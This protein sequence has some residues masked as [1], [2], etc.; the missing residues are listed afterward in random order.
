MI[1]KNIDRM[2]S[3]IQRDPALGAGEKLAV[4]LNRSCDSMLEDAFLLTP[5]GEVRDAFWAVSM[6]GCQ[7]DEASIT[8]TE[9]GAGV[10]AFRESQPS[11]RDGRPGG[12]QV[13]HDELYFPCVVFCNSGRESLTVDGQWIEPGEY[14]SVQETDPNRPEARWGLGA[15]IRSSE[16]Q[17]DAEG[18]CPGYGGRKSPEGRRV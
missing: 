3:E 4:C 13:C 5:E 18:P 9:N 6:N 12:I 1:T 17:T 14:V 2:L 11:S 7:P 10:A 15:S 16:A 8:L